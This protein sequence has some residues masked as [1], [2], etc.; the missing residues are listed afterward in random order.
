MGKSRMQC[1]IGVL[2]G[3]LP[4]RLTK[5]EISL[6]RSLRQDRG[7]CSQVHLKIRLHRQEMTMMS[8][9][10]LRLRRQTKGM[11]TC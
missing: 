6:L 11:L 8:S 4:K 1:E 10:A 3:K 7:P 5:L 9:W 2:K